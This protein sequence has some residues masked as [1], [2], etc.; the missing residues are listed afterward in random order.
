MHFCIFSYFSS[1]TKLLHDGLCNLWH[2]DCS[3]S[4]PVKLFHYK[5]CR[6][7]SFCKVSFCI[8]NKPYRFLTPQVYLAYIVTVSL[9]GLSI[10]ATVITSPVLDSDTM[11]TREHAQLEM[12]PCIPG[13]ARPIW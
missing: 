12:L 13:K 2:V 8:D 5:I 6:T 9:V 10:M 3:F 7:C 4:S 11:T 1:G